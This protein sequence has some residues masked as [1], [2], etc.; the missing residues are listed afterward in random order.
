MRLNRHGDSEFLPS[1]FEEQRQAESLGHGLHGRA[2]REERSENARNS[3]NFQRGHHQQPSFGCA[4]CTG[5]ESQ[6]GETCSIRY[7]PTCLKKSHVFSLNARARFYPLSDNL[8]PPL[9]PFFPFPFLPLSAVA[10]VSPA[11]RSP[12]ILFHAAHD[13]SFSRPLQTLWI[14]QVGDTAGLS[15]FHR[16]DWIF[17]RIVRQPR[18]SSFDRLISYADYR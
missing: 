1:P 15:K 4:G 9:Y 11:I 5:R 12:A 14:L 6:L 2:R 3:S 18:L 13:R 17:D 7:R 8:S 10:L 16:G